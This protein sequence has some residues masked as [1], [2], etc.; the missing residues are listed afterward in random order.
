MFTKWSKKEVGKFVLCFVIM[1]VLILLTELPGFLS[2]FYWSVFSIGSAFVAVGPITYVMNMKKGFGSSAVLILLWFLLNR[3]VGELGMP[4]MWIWILA[5]AVIVEVLR[6]IIGYDK[7]TSI[8]VCAPIAALT[9]FAPIAPLYFSK[10]EFL[11]KALEE[12][13]SDY[14][15]GLDK[16]GTIL[17]CV[18]VLVLMLVVGI[19]G[20]RLTEKIAKF[21]S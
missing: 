2:P 10:E 14:V 3:C 6:A 7:I 15:A 4:L 19:I 11:S 1:F 20:E 13:S 16:Y 5:V 8:R 9:P 12:M 18:I 21:E 17:T